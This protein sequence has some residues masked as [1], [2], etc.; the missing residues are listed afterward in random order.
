MFLN[1]EIEQR[2]EAEG[3][4]TSRR[5]INWL[6]CLL[7]ALVLITHFDL[8]FIFILQKTRNGNLTLYNKQLHVHSTAPESN[9]TADTKLIDTAESDVTTEAVINSYYKIP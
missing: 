1:V 6:M 7:M 2:F 8:V 9:L 5:A 4:R 3:R